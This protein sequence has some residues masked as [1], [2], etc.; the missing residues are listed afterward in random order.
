MFKMCLFPVGV[1][2]EA[3]KRIKVEELPRKQLVIKGVITGMMRLSW[4]L[5]KLV[6]WPQSLLSSETESRQQLPRTK[7]FFSTAASTSI[8]DSEDQ[9]F[10]YI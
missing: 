5:Q 8:S 2:A 10:R 7:S 4:R 3:V 9:D 6:I 1:G